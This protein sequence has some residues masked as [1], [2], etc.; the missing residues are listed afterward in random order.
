MGAPVA[1][2]YTSVL[3]YLLPYVEQDNVYKQ[4]IGGKQDL[5]TPN[6]QYF[7]LNSQAGAWAYNNAPFSSDGNNT[8]YYRI[9]GLPSPLEAHIPIYEC[10]SDNPYESVPA[11]HG[12]IDALFVYQNSYWIDFLYD[13]PGF[14]HELGASNYAANGGYFGNATGTTGCTATRAQTF[15]GPYA[16]NSKTTLQSIQDGTSNTIAFGETLGSS[17]TTHDW[18]LTWMG[19]GML[20][21]YG[22]IPGGPTDGPWV[23]SSRHSGGIVNFGY[24]DGSIRAIRSGITQQFDTATPCRNPVGQYLAWLSACGMNDG[25]VINFSQLE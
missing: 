11:G 9:P 6:S 12:P 3:A 8:G 20:A 25:Q 5:G 15:K 7:V 10:P 16:T 1:G 4:L 21:T 19:S 17:A 18:R 2:P 22:G 23:F 14:G 13:T 24:C